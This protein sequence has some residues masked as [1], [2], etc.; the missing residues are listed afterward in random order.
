M[1]MS[2]E[3]H[4]LREIARIY[5]D[6]KNPVAIISGNAQLLNEIARGLDLPADLKEP[7]ADIEEASE[8]L[9]ARVERLRNLGKKG[10]SDSGTA[11]F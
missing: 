5:H 4:L 6:I 1:S 2:E 3:E 8:E 11:S 10:G 7:I 9:T